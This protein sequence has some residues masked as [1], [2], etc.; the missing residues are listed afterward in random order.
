MVTTKQN[1]RVPKQEK[2]ETKR[3]VENQHFTKVDRNGGE[4]N[5]QGATK[6]SKVRHK[7]SVLRSSISIITLN[8]KN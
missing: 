6:Q 5:K 4:G 8:I 7:G 1:S 2:G 3:T